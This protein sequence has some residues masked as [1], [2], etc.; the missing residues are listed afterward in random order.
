[1][2]RDQFKLL[3]GVTRSCT[4]EGHLSGPSIQD[5]TIP[6]MVRNFSA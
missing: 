6:P 3:K 5:S 4:D 1:M 2:G